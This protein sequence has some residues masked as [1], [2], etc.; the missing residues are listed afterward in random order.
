MLINKGAKLDHRSAPSSDIS[1]KEHFFVCNDLQIPS[2]KKKYNLAQNLPS[3]L[4][5]NI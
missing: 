1:T 4:S 3:S 5:R 2:Q